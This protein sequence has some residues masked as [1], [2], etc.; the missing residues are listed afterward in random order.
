[1]GERYPYIPKEYYSAVLCA[2]AC[3]RKYGTF[4][5]AVKYAAEKYDLNEEKIAKYVRQRQGAGQRGKTREYRYFVFWGWLDEW[6]HDYD[7]DL[8]LSKADP[9]KWEEEKEPFVQIIK[10]TNFENAKKKLPAP[11]FDRDYRLRGRTV[12]DA[13]FVEFKTEKDAKRFADDVKIVVSTTQSFDGVE[14]KE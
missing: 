7:V 12:A 6:I 9:D 2:C 10:A 1:M 14:Y 5:R 11:Y 3:I 8:L 13:K 4:N